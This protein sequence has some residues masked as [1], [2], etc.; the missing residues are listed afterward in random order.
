MFLADTAVF[1]PQIVWENNDVR[2]IIFP[3]LSEK[4]REY[5]VNLLNITLETK[6]IK[7]K[8]SLAY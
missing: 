5:I 4:K 6:V 2:F 7:L 8:E 3:Y 1:E